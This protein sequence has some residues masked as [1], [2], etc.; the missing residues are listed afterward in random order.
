[1]LK[2]HGVFAVTVPQTSSGAAPAIREMS[3]SAV[4]ALSEE[5][6]VTLGSNENPFGEKNKNKLLSKTL[7]LLSKEIG[8]FQVAS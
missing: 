6:G 4:K 5:K 8:Y 7:F 2:A 1:M 3:R